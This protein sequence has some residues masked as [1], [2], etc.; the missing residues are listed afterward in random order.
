M[1][2]A[3]DEGGTTQHTYSSVHAQVIRAVVLVLVLSFHPSFD[4][5]LPR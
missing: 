4:A 2:A 5:V 1:T 3:D